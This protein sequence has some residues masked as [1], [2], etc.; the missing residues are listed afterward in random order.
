MEKKTKLDLI[1][2]GYEAARD[3]KPEKKYPIGDMIKQLL[4][5]AYDLGMLTEAGNVLPTFDQWVASIDHQS[6]TPT[7]I[8]WVKASERLP[9]KCGKE[10]TVIVR[11]MWEG[12][13]PFVTYGFRNYNEEKPQMYYELGSKSDCNNNVEWLDES[14]QSQQAG[15]EVEFAEW[16]QKN[17]W[18]S[19]ENGKWYYTFEQGT[20]MSDKVY[21]KN[22]VKTTAELYEVFKKEVKP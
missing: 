19:F 17:R 7:G 18:C 11:G 9:D 3:N 20:A 15:R 22:Y 6:A 13:W 5:D 1:K 10:N 12:K 8:E 21:K 2:E 4:R 16:L 14:G